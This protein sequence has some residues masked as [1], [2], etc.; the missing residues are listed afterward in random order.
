MDARTLQSTI[1]AQQLN[2]PKCLVLDL[3]N[4]LQTMLQKNEKVSLG[5]ESSSYLK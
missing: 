2:C 3:I 1:K 5:W 4:P